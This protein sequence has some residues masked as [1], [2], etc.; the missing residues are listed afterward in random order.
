MKQVIYTICLFTLCLSHLSCEKIK[1]LIQMDVPLSFNYEITI[2]ASP[3]AEDITIPPVNIVTNI[4]QTIKDY[5]EESTFIEIRSVKLASATIEVI[6][7]NRYEN[8]NLTAIS[9]FNVN[10]NSSAQSMWSPL[11]QLNEVP[12]QPYELDLPV[13]TETN[14]KEYF[15]S[16]AFNFSG[17]FGLARPTTQS[18]KCKITIQVKINVSL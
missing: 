11:I 2:P 6:E 8:D 18:F 14:L 16:D 1:E 5:T 10:M 3:I 17:A 4:S 12:T 9:K 13:D 15:T 7:E